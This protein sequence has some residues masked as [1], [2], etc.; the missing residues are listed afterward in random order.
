MTLRKL[1]FI[2]QNEEKAEEKSS[3]GYK[4]LKVAKNNDLTFVGLLFSVVVKNHQK[5]YESV[6]P[7]ILLQQCFFSGGHI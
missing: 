2:P 4:T 7:V 5:M 6:F 1:D 3:G